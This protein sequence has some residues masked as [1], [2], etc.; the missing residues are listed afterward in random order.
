MKKTEPMIKNFSSDVLQRQMKCG[1]NFAQT[2]FSFVVVGNNFYIFY[3]GLHMVWSERSKNLCSKCFIMESNL[4]IF[5]MI[6]YSA[7]DNCGNK[8]SF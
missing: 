5:H 2:I 8:W 6:E 3:I 7:T 4:L 1:N